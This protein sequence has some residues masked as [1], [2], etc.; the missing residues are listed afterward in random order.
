MIKA[1][2]AACGGG[3]QVLVS[4]CMR[5][6]VTQ[7]YYDR[8]ERAEALAAAKADSKSGKASGGSGAAGSGV[9]AQAEAHAFIRALMV[10]TTEPS[11]ELIRS[12]VQQVRQAL[13]A[14]A[15]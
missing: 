14:P 11:P 9:D 1:T 2:R 6:A 3:M 8:N 13:T 10:D 15:C 5:H 4:H 7:W 12:L